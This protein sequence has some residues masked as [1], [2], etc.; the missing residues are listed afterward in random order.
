MTDA[1]VRVKSLSKQYMMPDGEIVP[2]LS[3]VTLFIEPG[4]HI[5][6]IGPSGSGKSTLLHIMAGL[7]SPSKGSVDWPALGPSDGLMPTRLQVVF[8]MA[9]LF[10]PLNVLENVALPMVL[11]GHQAQA[12][13]RALAMLQ[14][15]GLVDLAPKL[16]EE[17]S[18]GQAQRVA[19]A[20][21]LAITPALILADE[22]TGQLDSTTAG[23]FLDEVIAVAGES[24]TALVIATHDATIAAR[25]QTVWTV[26][27]GNLQFQPEMMGGLT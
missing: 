8:Q 15:L 16:P 6:L 22:P 17:L 3:D 12:E 2:V 23:A 5:V 7:V 27:R 25:M 1:L 14:R 13:V 9:S 11:A 19:V 21:A 4:Q 26:S 20:R 24:D 18:G 10:P